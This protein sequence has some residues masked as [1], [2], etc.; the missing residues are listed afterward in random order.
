MKYFIRYSLY[1]NKSNSFL[2]FVYCYYQFRVSP[3]QAKKKIVVKR[4][5]LD[6]HSV[7]VPKRYSLYIGSSYDLKRSL[8]SLQRLN[9]I[10]EMINSGN[11]CLTPK[12]SLS[13]KYQMLT[14]A[15]LSDYVV[16]IGILEDSAVV[17]IQVRLQLLSH[18]AS[19]QILHT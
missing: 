2:D 14:A 16:N 7:S 18:K 3:H 4:Q 15:D 13:Q 12:L 19:L 6:K 17:C 11:S 1:L 8:V 9:K 10:G 5:K